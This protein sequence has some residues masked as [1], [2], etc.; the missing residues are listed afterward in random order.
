M[1]EMI[2]QYNPEVVILLE[3]R[4]QFVRVSHFWSSLNY[5]PC[6]IE[7]AVGFSEGIWV[8][9]HRNSGVSMKIMNQYY[10]AITFEVWRENLSWI[11]SAVYASPVPTKREDLW[12]HLEELRTNIVLPWMLVGDFNEIFGTQRFV[13]ETW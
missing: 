1:K 12:R 6:F 11:C 13:M 10:Q 3:T 8:L 5:Y 9:L 2:R 4:C 7:E